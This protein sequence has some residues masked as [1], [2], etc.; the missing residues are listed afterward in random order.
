MWKT[1]KEMESYRNVHTNLHQII[2]YGLSRSYVA[3]S[4]HANTHSHTHA[5][6]RISNDRNKAWNLQT[7][8]PCWWVW[9]RFEWN[10]VPNVWRTQSQTFHK[11][12]RYID[13]LPASLFSGDSELCMRFSHPVTTC[14]IW[15]L[16]ILWFSPLLSLCVC[17][18][19]K[20]NT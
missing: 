14:P 2:E 20:A 19:S 16:L 10:A 13:R 15:L 12:Y 18:P 1:E 17:V 5:H 7:T 4:F 3:R 6:W 8:H 9:W 11:L